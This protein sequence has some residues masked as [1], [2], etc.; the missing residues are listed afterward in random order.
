MPTNEDGR[1]S[2]SGRSRRVVSQAVGM[3]CFYFNNFFTKC[4]LT[5]RTTMAMTNGDHHHN[6][7][8]SLAP[9]RARGSMF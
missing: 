3:L 7:T 8:P 4:W 6:H 2:R 1:G 5:T 9:E